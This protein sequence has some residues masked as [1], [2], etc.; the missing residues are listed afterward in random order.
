LLTASAALVAGLMTRR[1]F[2][3]LLA[4]WVLMG[5]LTRG[6]QARPRT[7]IPPMT[8]DRPVEPSDGDE[9]APTPTQVEADPQPEA[10][11]HPGPEPEPEH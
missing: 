6:R 4:G 11:Q 8:F 1:I 7:P 10:G 2:L 5:E 9:D 3:A